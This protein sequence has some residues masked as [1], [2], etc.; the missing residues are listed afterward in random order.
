[1]F[2]SSQ[3]R[4]LRDMYDGYEKIYITPDVND[5]HILRK[6]TGYG[7]DYEADDC[8]TI[9]E[10]TNDRKITKRDY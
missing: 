9:I 8:K 3:K 5:Y 1:M 7:E 6:I 10:H 2:Q 4:T